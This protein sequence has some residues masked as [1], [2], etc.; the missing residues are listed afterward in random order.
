MGLFNI[1]NLNTELTRIESQSKAA[2]SVDAIR[3]LIDDISEIE[4]LIELLRASLGNR[5]QLI[6]LRRDIETRLLQQVELYQRKAALPAELPHFGDF[7]TD[8][9]ICDVA[10]CQNPEVLMRI[11]ATDKTA[12][13]VYK[14]TKCEHYGETVVDPATARQ[15]IKTGTRCD[16]DHFK[17]VPIGDVRMG[18][19]EEKRIKEKE[20]E[21]P[22][23]DV[24]EKES[25]G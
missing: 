25:T 10:D 23:K 1:D 12:R 5:Q 3:T 16:F 14:C 2:L 20:K 18:E 22:V 9:Y 6:D 8:I 11:L 15:I 19:K 17:P 24:D 4:S 21:N 13:A 7:L